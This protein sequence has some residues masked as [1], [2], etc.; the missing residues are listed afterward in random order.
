MKGAYAGLS[1]D[2]STGI[3]FGVK[4]PTGE[5]TY[6]NFDSDTEI[7]SGSTDLLFGVYQLGKVTADN[8]W[9]W[10]ANAQ[11]QQ[12]LRHK[13][14]Y[15]PGA[16]LDGAGGVYYGGWMFGGTRLTPIVQLELT[17]RRHDGGPDGNPLDTGYV[18]A[19]AA[20]GV[21]VD[22]RRAVGLSGP[23]A[24][25]TSVTGHFLAD[26]G[27]GSPKAPGDGSIAVARSHA[28]RDLLALTE[29]EHLR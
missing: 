26:R 2:L 18:R 17:Y 28:A 20:S 13:A 1:A 22:A 12:P 9:S 29:A 24:R 21:E 25:S 4:L 5:S 23:I 6:P 10:F 19:Y 14:A 15:R 16:E 27:N 7:G 8:R 3:T 11:W